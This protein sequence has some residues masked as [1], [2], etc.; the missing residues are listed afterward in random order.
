ML[1][2]QAIC[3]LSDRRKWSKEHIKVL[4]KEWPL[5]RSP[6]GLAVCREIAKTH[7]LDRTGK[8]VLDKWRQLKKI[9]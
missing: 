6:P 2:H 1:A 4:L 3:N 5:S 7:Q 9:M 8:Q